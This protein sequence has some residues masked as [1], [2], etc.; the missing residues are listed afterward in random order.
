MN[1]YYEWMLMVK[2]MWIWSFKFR[3][4]KVIS[5][6]LPGEIKELVS[7]RTIFNTN[8]GYECVHIYKYLHP[9]E[10]YLLLFSSTCYMN[11]CN[12]GKKRVT[13]FLVHSFIYIYHR[14]IYCY[15]CR[16]VSIYFNIPT[17]NV[18]FMTW[19]FMNACNEKKNA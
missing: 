9:F 11:F 15:S 14:G 6:F 19:I 18:S 1:L 7:K 17:A 16:H 12:Y 8:V 4:K 3:W 10:H 5:Q 2:G 13:K